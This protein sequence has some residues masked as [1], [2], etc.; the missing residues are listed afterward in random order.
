MTQKFFSVMVPTRNR[1]ELLSKNLLSLK[2]Q[3]FEDFEVVVSD[4]SLPSNRD[5]VAEIV[6]SLG[7]ARFKLVYAPRDMPMG[8]HWEWLIGHATGKWVGILTDRTALVRTALSE[9]SRC[10]RDPKVRLLSYPFNCLIGDSAP[11]R[12]EQVPFSNEVVEINSA[13]MLSAFANCLGHFP[14]LAPRMMNSFCK[15]EVLREMTNKFGSVFVSS[16]P[17]YYFCFLSLCHLDSV[18]YFDRP[19]QI[20]FGQS[21]SNGVSFHRGTFSSDGLDFLNRL[22]EGAGNTGTPTPRLF[23]SFSGVMHEY[24][25]VRD[26]CEGSRF[27]KINYQAY[28]D[29]LNRDLLVQRGTQ[30]GRRNRLLL[31]EFRVREGLRR[32]NFDWLFFFREFAGKTGVHWVLKP[33]FQWIALHFHWDPLG[34]LQRLWSRPLSSVEEAIDFAGD[35]LRRPQ[36]FQEIENK[37]EVIFKRASSR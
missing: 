17:D 6:S 31:E 27:P 9:V 22:E 24:G 14:T 8:E 11:F 20:S 33:V 2:K 18:H 12:L 4:N 16:S 1:P 32:S 26:F 19:V 35:E 36:P 29:K 37:I 21:V 34:V 15:L 13:E 23:T 10:F 28:Y 30:F 7:D 5:K 3:D 25:L